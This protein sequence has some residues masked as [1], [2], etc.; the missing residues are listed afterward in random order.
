MRLFLLNIVCAISK[1]LGSTIGSHPY[2]PQ[3]TQLDT[4]KQIKPLKTIQLMVAVIVDRRRRDALP[5][6]FDSLKYQTIGQNMFAPLVFDRNELTGATKKQLALTT[7]R[8]NKI[9]YLAFTDGQCAV[10]ADWLRT[11][12]KTMED[13]ESTV[14]VGKTLRLNTTA[15]W[16]TRDLSV[17]QSANGTVFYGF[18]TNMLIDVERLPREINF[19]TTIPDNQI[20]LEDIDFCLKIRHIY[21]NTIKYSSSSLVINREIHNDDAFSVIKQHF[22]VGRGI[23]LFT[24]RYKEAGLVI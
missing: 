21:K 2:H 4:P 6:L 15:G 5:T 13:E 22:D 12:L 11:L 3:N 20:G 8:A 19:D 17:K 16:N 14:V 18:S 23:T 24:E 10:C 9:R 1:F 7:A